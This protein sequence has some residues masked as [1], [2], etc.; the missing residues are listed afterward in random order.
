MGDIVF[1]YNRVIRVDVILCI[2]MYF[3][4]YLFNFI[5]IVSFCILKNCI[6]S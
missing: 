4:L 6:F 3:E 2:Y 5:V 1:I